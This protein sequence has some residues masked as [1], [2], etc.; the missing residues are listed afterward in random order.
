MLHRKHSNA[1]ADELTTVSNLRLINRAER[2]Q[3]GDM[4]KV[5]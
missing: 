4:Q 2:W 5:E 3:N 1:M